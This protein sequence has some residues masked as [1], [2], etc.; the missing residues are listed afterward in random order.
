MARKVS[1]QS[2]WDQLPVGTVARIETVEVD[3]DGGETDIII[4][5]LRVE[6]DIRVDAGD[7]MLAGGKHWHIAFE[8][9]Q[10]AL[11]APVT[12]LFA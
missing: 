5:V 1:D 12:E 9:D 2:E 7:Y 4:F 8:W 3:D 11:V 6:G 10:D